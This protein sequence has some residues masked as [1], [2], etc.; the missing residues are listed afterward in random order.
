MVV[1]DKD[2]D[3]LVDGAEFLSKFFMI[4][5][6]EQRKLYGDKGRPKTVELPS[7][8]GQ[9]KPK[10]VMISIGIQAPDDMRPRSSPDKMAMNYTSMA[11]NVGTSTVIEKD[12]GTMDEY[13]P[14]ARKLIEERKEKEKVKV[15]EKGKERGENV[16]LQVKVL[17]TEPERKEG[18]SEKVRKGKDRGEAGALS[19]AMTAPIDGRKRRLKSRGKQRAGTAAAGSGRRR[20]DVVFDEWER[21]QEEGISEEH[22]G[23]GKGPVFFFPSLILTSP[24]SMPSLKGSQPL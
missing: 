18:G 21:K 13:K 22:G 15:K 5:R 23:G 16:K 6:D 2:G 8:G 24:I 19:R 9:R 10:K 17:V 14:I 12:S 7:R 3:K 20:R 11:N 1:F 4:A